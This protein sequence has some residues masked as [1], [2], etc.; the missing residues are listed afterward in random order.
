MKLAKNYI[1]VGVQTNQY[2][3]MAEF[4]QNQIGLPFEELLKVGGG[5]HQ[6]R[7]SLNG[8]I[9]KLNSVREPLPSSEKTGYNELLIAT[10]KVTSPTL[11]TDPDGS[12]VTLVPPGYNGITNIG[13][14][15]EVSS[16]EKFRHFYSEILQIEKVSENCFQWGTTLLFLKE[17]KNHRRCDMMQGIGFRYI[18]VQIWNVEEEHQAILS[19]GGEEGRAPVVLGSTAKI[20][21]IKDPDGNWIEIS[22]RASLT[23]DLS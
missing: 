8:S 16:L 18:T 4:W 20:S 14:K 11:F 1:D 6:H 9:F 17:N 21:F 19:R 5:I 10:E 22:Q 15:M 2:E 23:G 3:A 12:N 7:H 13:L